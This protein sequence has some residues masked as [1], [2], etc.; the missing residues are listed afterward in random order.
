MN[1]SCIFAGYFSC[2]FMR[3]YIYYITV[4]ILLSVG[5]C[6]TVHAQDAYRTKVFRDD[7]GSLEI[8]VEGELISTPF[9]ELNGEKVIEISFDALHRTSGRFAYSV[10]HCD[11]G[12]KQS[13][14]LSIEYMK[15]FQRAAIEDFTNA[16]GTTT[17]YTHY[18]LFLPNDDVQLT[19]SGNYAVQVF[20]ED[21]PDRIV[22]TA[23]FSI[24]EP[25]IDIE[26][27]ITGNTVI[28][29]NREHQQVDFDINTK[30]LNIA[31]P[32]HDLKI[33]VYQNSNPDDIRT[34]LQP[35]MISSRQIQY[36]RNREL[37]FEAGNEFRRI[38]FQTHRTKGMGVEETGFYN[39]YYHITLFQDQKRNKKPYQYD[40]DQNGRFFILC[41]GCNDP[42]REGDYYVVHFSLASEPMPNGTMYLYGDFFNCILDTRSQMEYN[43]ENGAYEKEILLKTGLYNYQYVFMEDGDTKTSFKRTEGNFFET[44]NEYNIL[45]YYRPP[46]ARYDRL[47]GYKNTRNF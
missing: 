14:L 12:W 45:V 5:D 34:D 7:I 47:V 38:E 25:L 32:Q 2:F 43:A 6:A 41:N 39:P 3:T 44:E 24:V 16:I 4:G 22:F 37:I 26:A 10:I 27:N 15:G 28:D 46:G 8:K 19:T 29:F 31:F 1:F 11:A 21:N 33:F 23:C 36:R 17:N 35:S 20:D 40:R 9:I 18:R 42:G 30:N 13:N